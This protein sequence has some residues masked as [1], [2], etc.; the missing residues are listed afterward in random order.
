MP[1][2]ATPGTYKEMVGDQRDERSIRADCE[3]GA[4]PCLPRPGGTGS[5]HRIATAR[6]LAQLGIPFTIKAVAS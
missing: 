3:S 6:A 4:I 5:R 1:L 2:T